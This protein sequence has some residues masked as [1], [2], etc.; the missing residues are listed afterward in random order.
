[1]GLFFCLDTSGSMGAKIGG[2]AKIDISKDAMRK[3]FAQ[4]AD[5]VKAHPEKTVK[6]GLC[7]FHSQPALLRGMGPFDR[8]ELEQAIKP[9]V[10]KG[11]TAIGEAMALATKELVRSGVETRA[12]IVMTDGENTHGVTPDR[13]VDAIKQDRN[14]QNLTTVDI[15]VFM[16]A[17]DV[18]ARVFDGVKHAGGAV[19]ES[20][21]QRSLE[22]IL[23]TLVEEILLEKPK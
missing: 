22:S 5:Y 4:V 15:E 14:Q 23:N 1:V 2:R 12:I 10:A 18:N 3:V 17:F 7:S 20:N 13:I 19:K 9:L 8:Q 21:D 6:V 16:V 11:G